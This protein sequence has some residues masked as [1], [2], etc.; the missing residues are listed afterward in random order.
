LTKIGPVFKPSGTAIASAH[1]Q[2]K[3]T[4]ERRDSGSG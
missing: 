4:S 3:A 1:I 2:C